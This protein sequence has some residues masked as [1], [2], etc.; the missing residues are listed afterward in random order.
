MLKNF[1]K[2]LIE[3]YCFSPD[4]NGNPFVAV[5]DTKDWEWIAGIASD[6]I[7]D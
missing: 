4:S 5:F 1:E 6:K 2:V 3:N 7:P